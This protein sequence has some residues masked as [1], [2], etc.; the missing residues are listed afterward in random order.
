MK[1]TTYTLYIIITLLCTLTSCESHR[2]NNGDLGGNWQLT[3]WETRNEQTGNI[4]QVVCGTESKIFYAI[5][6]DL[7]KFSNGNP[8]NYHLS[9]FKNE[10]HV[11]SFYNITH[12]PTD[13]LCTTVDLSKYGIPASGQLH[14]DK[15]DS[16]CLVVSYT[17]NRLTFR[18][19]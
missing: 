19:Y 6:R 8:A 16:E 3:R 1:A 11:L 7:F 14:I 5:H 15:L 18:K 17:D 9:Y 13:S 2:D 12:Y 10:N 4:D